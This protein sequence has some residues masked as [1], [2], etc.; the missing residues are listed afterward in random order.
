MKNF[1]ARQRQEGFFTVRFKSAAGK[2]STAQLLAIHELTETFGKGVINLTSRQEI[3][4]PFV[5]KEC[6][7]AIKKFGEAH[8]NSA[9]LTI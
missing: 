3:S 2:F 5:R 8:E 4:I 6:F 1:L 7:D 9:R